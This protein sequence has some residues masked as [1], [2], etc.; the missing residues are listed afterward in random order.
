MPHTVQTQER[1]TD[2]HGIVIVRFRSSSAIGRL[3]RRR[4]AFIDYLPTHY[5]RALYEELGRRMDADFYFYAD[6]RERYWNKALSLVGDGRFRRVE[7]RR[8]RIAGEAFMPGIVRMVSAERYDAVIK[9]L[10]GRVML[11]LTYF[12]A[13]AR[14][15]AFVLWSGMW[16][17]PRT[18]FHR[19]SR[20]PTEW[21]YRDADA[22][23]A[24]GDHVRRYVLQAPGVDAEKVF[25][26]G[27]AVDAAPF[28]AVRPDFDTDVAE[29]VYVGQ[30]EER[31]GIEFLLDAFAMLRNEGV[32]ARLRLIGNGSMEDEIRVR[33]AASDAIEIV[34]HVPQERLPAQLARARCL[35][36][37]SIT[38]DLDREPWGLVCNEAMHAGLPVVA[39]DA[40]GAAVGGLVRDR[41]N[42]FV[43]PERDSHSLASALRRLVQDAHLAREMGARARTDAAAFDHRRMAD[44]FEAAVEHAVAARS[45]R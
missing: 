13:R 2:A 43:V 11:P 10:N 4:I 33:T 32:A 30:F 18:P 17:H 39:S 21:L 27:Q 41:W 25:V 16:Y 6:Q 31:K 35:V 42:G 34:G 22:I 20:V 9:S 38:T 15:V 14:G 7:L 37:P 36:L 26:A 8:F 19:V 24:Y 28:A 29:V 44:G 12:T 40:V 23:V 3:V 45:L 5:R 1:A